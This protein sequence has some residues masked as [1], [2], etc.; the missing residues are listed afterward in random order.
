MLVHFVTDEKIPAIRAMLEPRYYVVP[1]YWAVV[2][3]K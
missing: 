3:R 2:T 1:S